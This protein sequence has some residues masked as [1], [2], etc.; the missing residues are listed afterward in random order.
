MEPGIHITLTSARVGNSRELDFV[1]LDSRLSEKL[2]QIINKANAPF[3][4]NN[5]C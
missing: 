3:I 1:D 4:C 2:H 5:Y